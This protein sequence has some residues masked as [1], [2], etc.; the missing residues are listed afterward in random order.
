MSASQAFPSVTQL[1]KLQIDAVERWHR[2]P[3]DNPFSG[4]ETSIE[5]LVCQQHEFNYRLWHEED[6][7]RSPSATD[8]E[9]A[10][11]KRAIDKLNQARNDMIEKVDDAITAMIA[12]AGVD[13]KDAPINTETS[14]SAI[15]RLSIMALRLY[16]YREQADREGIDAEQRQ[17]V[18]DRIALC[19]QQH[20]DLSKSLQQQ[21]DDIFAGRR[22]H[23]TYR[24]MKMYNDPSLNPAIYG[25]K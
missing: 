8:Q 21:L 6:T 19:E 13:A 1:T 24:Q 16:H 15:D 2:E 22:Q 5:A 20:A 11:V 12:S 25:S 14:G 10:Q 4:S 7:A 18:L 23:R 9:I 3:I 17:K